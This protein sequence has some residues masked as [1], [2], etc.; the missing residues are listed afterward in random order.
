M[1]DRVIEWDVINHPA[2]WPNANMLTARPGLEK[3][4]REIFTLARKKT[5]LPFYVNEDRIF[6]PGR[7]SDETPDTSRRSTPTASRS[8]GWATRPIST[9][10]ACRPRRKC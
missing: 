7:Q 5:A 9:P 3:L 8:T 10:A 6:W 4:D 2:A 1:K